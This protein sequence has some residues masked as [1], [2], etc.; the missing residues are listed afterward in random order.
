MNPP[1][2][3][4][5]PPPLQNVVF[6]L[7][8]A[9]AKGSTAARKAITA[10]GLDRLP[11]PPDAR[12]RGPRTSF[13]FRL[14]RWDTE[15]G[16]M[17]D[18]RGSAGRGSTGSSAGRPRGAGGS[19]DGEAAAAAVMFSP[20]EGLE[21][22]QGAGGDGGVLGAVLLGVAGLAS[23]PIRGLDEGRW[24]CFELGAQLDTILCL[25][26]FLSIVVHTVWSGPPAP[27]L[28]LPP[29]VRPPLPAFLPNAGGL[30]GLLA[31]IKRGAIGVVVLPLASLLE[32]LAGASDS[33]RRAVAG[34]SN[35]G[36]VRPPRWVGKERGT[37]SMLCVCCA[38]W[39][40]AGLLLGPRIW[41]RDAG[42]KGCE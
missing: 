14:Q 21:G 29:Q 34:S 28:P 18:S 26:V 7:S 30:W 1:C 16:L 4:A 37:E 40:Q 42:S 35:V 32:M 33:I 15:Q 5:P 27:P 13:Q 6:A 8:N 41:L 3:R 20:R 31:G 17:A 24:W 39:R 10:L 38:R 19:S 12:P 11:V 9:A 25:S 23:E 2:A 36:W 22:P